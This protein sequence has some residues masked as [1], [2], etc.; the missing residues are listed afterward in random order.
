M[1]VRLQINW[2]RHLT[3]EEIEF[4][5]IHGCV[6]I[7]FHRVLFD[8]L[9]RNVIDWQKVENLI[10]DALQ[11]LKTRY[12]VDRATGQIVIRCGDSPIEPFMKALDHLSLMT[13]ITHTKD[14]TPAFG[15]EVMITQTSQYGMTFWV[16]NPSQRE[17]EEKAAR[18]TASNVNLAKRSELALTK[19]TRRASKR[20]RR[21]NLHLFDL[22]MDNSVP[23]N[24]SYC[25]QEPE[26]Q[27]QVQEVQV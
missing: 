7:E 21:I 11:G 25:V 24:I 23:L 26:V 8:E 13:V 10:A 16:C 17:L 12:G 6:G 22:V 18:H 20:N 1:P 19:K 14:L 9:P 15:P 4:S 3:A 27:P 2:A 5:R